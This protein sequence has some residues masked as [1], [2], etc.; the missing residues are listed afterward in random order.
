MK[1][2]VMVVDNH[3]DQ[4]FT[5]KQ[6]LEYSSD[7]FEVI[8]VNSCEQCLQV[9]ENGEI[10]DIILTETRMPGMNGWELLDK[11]KVNRTW[12][13]IPVLFLTAWSD[14]KTKEL[15][16]EKPFDLKELRERIDTFMKRK[17]GKDEKKDHGC[18]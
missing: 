6:A 13:R 10:P 5:L 11:L 8:G 7:E 4:I 14:L 12:E 3:A 2:K 1:K 9:L 15:I 16:I 17:G 18:G